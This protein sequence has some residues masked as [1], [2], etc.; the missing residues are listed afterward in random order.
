VSGLQAAATPDK[1]LRQCHATWTSIA[2][3]ELDGRS[4]E[5]LGI[6]FTTRCYDHRADGCHRR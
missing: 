3:T 5:R 6:A 1:G 2:F 4:R